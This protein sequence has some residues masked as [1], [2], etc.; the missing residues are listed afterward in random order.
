MSPRVQDVSPPR[1]TA[2][3]D[4]TPT[5]LQMR[6]WLVCNFTPVPCEETQVSVHSSASPHLGRSADKNTFDGGEQKMFG[7]Q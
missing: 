4:N 3:C 5:T 2:R 7:K 6:E 1:L